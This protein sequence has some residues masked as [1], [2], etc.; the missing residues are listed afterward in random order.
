[1]RPPHGRQDPNATDRLISPSLAA[2]LAAALAAGPWPALAVTSLLWRV[3]LAIAALALAWRGVP[4]RGRVGLVSAVVVAALAVDALAPAAITPSRAAAA[5]SGQVSEIG[6]A[7]AREA[8]RGNLRTL[9]VG[10][11]GE[12]THQRI[13]P[14]QFFFSI[15]QT[16]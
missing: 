15:G 10:G 12:R 14:F 13:S 9:L 11:G 1:M 6:H 7:L 16:F 5:I 2:G 8:Q 3:P 4:A